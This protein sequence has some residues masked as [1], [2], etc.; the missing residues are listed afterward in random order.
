MQPRTERTALPGIGLK[1]IIG[2]VVAFIGAVVA[3]FL[4]ESGM[5]L[6][7]WEASWAESTGAMAI[8]MLV[9]AAVAVVMILIMKKNAQKA[10]A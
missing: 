4:S 1:M 7:D 9:A 10:Q 6:I 3:E 8:G 5:E 2:C